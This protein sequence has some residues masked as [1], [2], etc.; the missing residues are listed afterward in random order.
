MK[1]PTTK[2]GKYDYS[3]YIFDDSKIFF[4]H[5]CQWALFDAA[6]EAAN[7]VGKIRYA[8]TLK[9]LAAAAAKMAKPIFFQLVPVGV[10]MYV[11]MTL[12][13]GEREITLL[14]VPDSGANTSALSHEVA[15]YLGIDLKHCRKTKATVGAAQWSVEAYSTELMVRIGDGK[16]FVE[17]EVDFLKHKHTPTLLGWNAFF[18]THE[19]TFS[20]E[21]GIKYRFIG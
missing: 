5:L 18:A 10:G 3:Q 13:T 16:H 19:V 20:P 21:Y 9:E 14:A 6:K 2:K 15:E 1:T 7:K 8:A 11:P 12:F 17:A 4:D